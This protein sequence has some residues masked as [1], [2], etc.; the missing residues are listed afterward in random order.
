MGEYLLSVGSSDLNDLKSSF[1]NYARTLEIVGPGENVYSP[2]PDGRVA[3][4]SGTSM[5]AP[6]MAG[7]LALALGQGLKVSVKD[8]TKK[9]AESAFDVYNNGAN[10]AYKDMLGVKGRVDLVKFLKDTTQQ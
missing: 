10:E 1:S 7:G 4:W 9:M 2:Y 8:L 6:M 5:A 3:G